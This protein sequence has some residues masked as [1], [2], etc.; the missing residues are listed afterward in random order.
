MAFVTRS[1]RTPAIAPEYRG[2]NSDIGPGSYDDPT[3]TSK[4]GHGYAPFSTTAPRPLTT[5]EGTIR[6]TPGPGAY[7]EAPRASVTYTTGSSGFKTA[8]QRFVVEDR[9]NAPGPGY[10]KTSKSWIKSSHRVPVDPDARASGSKVLFQRSATAPSVPARGQSF[11][12]EETPHGDLVPQVA[13]TNDGFSGV[14]RDLPGP[15]DYDPKVDAL[16]RRHAPAVDFSRSK[17]ERGSWVA[18]KEDAPAPGQYDAAYAPPRKPVS[19][20]GSSAFVSQVALA[21]QVRVSEDK[22]TPGP[23]SYKADLAGRSTAGRAPEAYQ[24]FGS[25]AARVTGLGGGGIPAVGPGSYEDPRVGVARSHSVPAGRGGRYPSAAAESIGFKSTSD[26]FGPSTSLAPGPG[27]YQEEVQRKPISRP[28]GGFGTVGSRLDP[29]MLRA[30][31]ATSSDLGPGYYTGD[32]GGG[33]KAAKPWEVARKSSVFMSKVDRLPDPRTEAPPPGS[34]DVPLSQLTLKQTAA[35]PTPFAS[36][37]TRQ[38]PVANKDALAAPGPGAYDA[39]LPPNRV[40]AMWTPTPSFA[41]NI[42]RFSV[43]TEHHEKVL[44][45]GSYEP[46]GVSSLIKRS[47]NVTVDGV[48][49]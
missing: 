48:N 46:E 41:T 8:V 17:A 36:S 13:P 7:R 10:Y 27:A 21:H 5:A 45:P 3:L 43:R 40:T 38:A 29:A 11:G 24:P 19:R 6:Y 14:G 39:R 25:S 12:Y 26:R 15:G 1:K 35:K 33:K 28:P 47:F 23:G 37:T 20:K 18:P 16:P 31:G 49:F 34:Y 2:T 42:P 22:S 30:G 32:G 9:V 44:G 4:K